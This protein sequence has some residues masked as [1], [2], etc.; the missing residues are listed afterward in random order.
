MKA[1]LLGFYGDDGKK[2]ITELTSK[3]TFK[4]L[5]ML[6]NKV[7]INNADQLF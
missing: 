4:T 2:I 1:L 6:G 3:V 5:D 7:V